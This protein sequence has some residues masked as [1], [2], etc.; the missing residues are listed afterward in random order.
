MIDAIEGGLPV[1]HALLTRRLGATLAATAAFFL[2]LQ[3][4]YYA[5]VLAA[6]KDYVTSFGPVIGGDFAVFH[7][8]AKAAWSGPAAL[9][10]YETLNARLAEAFPA[11]ADEFRLGWQYPPTM[12]LAL[13]PL[14]AAPYP[15]AYGAWVAGGLAAFLL[16]ASSHWRSP[17]ALL[18]LAATPAVFQAA[19][20]GQTGLFA[21]A[22]F[23]LAAWAPDKRP[24]VAGLAAGLLTLK[25]QLGLLIPIAFAAAGAWRAFAIAAIAAASLAAAAYGAFGEVSWR[26]FFDAAALQGGYMGGSIGGDG[27]GIVFPLE[28][29]TSIFGAVAVAGAPST[30]AIAAQAVGF[31]VLA[32]VVVNV[33]RGK[34]GPDTKAAV[35]MLASLLATPYGFYY[36][37]PIAAGALFLLIRSARATRF[38]DGEGLGVA[39]LWLA[40]MF[41]PGHAAPAVPLVAGATFAAFAL[42]ARRA[43]H[44]DRAIRRNGV[45]P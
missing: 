36:E 42:A 45:T 25:P 19:I 32:A 22:L 16:A 37:L 29:L 18:L 28:K 44:E 31:L 11:F 2:C 13:A 9:Y 17:F 38:L 6:S 40:P 8:G 15:V 26:A 39:A 30:V 33:W 35:L 43:L 27:R 4:G 10:G 5:I 23:L 3:W 7:E 20:T 21:G 14:A 41:M 24:I 1:I 34:A 12:H